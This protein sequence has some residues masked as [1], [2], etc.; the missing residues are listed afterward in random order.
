MHTLNVYASAYVTAV[1]RGETKTAADA[2]A[3]KTVDAYLANE[4]KRNRAQPMRFIEWG[5]A[6]DALHFSTE[7]TA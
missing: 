1:E 2:S 6:A 5:G 4:R 3:W 7:Y